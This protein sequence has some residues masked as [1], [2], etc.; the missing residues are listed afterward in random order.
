MKKI[1]SFLAALAV[2][3]SLGAQA[4]ADGFM[5]SMN[6]VA[7]NNSGSINIIYN[8]QL[9]TYTDAVPENINDRVMLPFR[10]VL[11]GMGAE[12]DYE[13]SSRL[14]TA[15]RGDTTISFTLEDDTIY[16]NNNG[17]ETQLKMDVPM[18]IKNDRTLVP[19]R[20][21]SN[22]LGMQVGWEGDY[23]TVLIVD[24]DAYAEEIVQ[25]MPN[26]MSLTQM[27]AQEY[28]TSAM[29][30]S[31][32]IDGEKSSAYEPLSISADLKL[33]AKAAE[34]GLGINGNVSVSQ[35]GLTDINAFSV[36]NASVDIVLSDGKLYFKT[37]AISKIIEAE[38]SQSLPDFDTNVWFCVDADSLI[39]KLFGENV[40]D[41]VKNI[42]KQLFSG[43][44]ANINQEEFI[45]I[46]KSQFMSEGDATLD[47]AFMA[48]MTADMYKAIDKYIKITDNSVEIKLDNQALAEMLAGM[49]EEI[50]SPALDMIT[51]NVDVV[52]NYED[53][54]AASTAVI[55]MGINDGDTKINMS[56]NISETDKAEE[57]I[58]PVEI[59]E[60]AVDFMSVINLLSFMN[61]E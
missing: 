20:F 52:S 40:P 43:K 54:Q 15:V 26:L 30:M 14:V 58:A 29:D 28:N 5:Q 10:A 22:A 33:E 39:E 3:A 23:D 55:T 4:Y 17:T 11:E 47:S 13:D 35:S 48:D 24:T 6:T 41:S 59:P 37:D 25:N 27:Q 18:I 19:I 44:T 61:Q 2:T 38:G 34:N 21:I 50:I 31:L 42:Y 36:E 45:N 46:I 8:G 51:L 7:A 1:I 12:V 16:I 53:N 9:M 57:N 32:K 60:N 56:F 49:P